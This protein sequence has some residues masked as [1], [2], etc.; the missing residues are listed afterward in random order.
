[1][2]HKRFATLERHLP[3]LNCMFERLTKGMLHCTHSSSKFKFGWLTNRKPAFSSCK[4]SAW[5]AP[6]GMWHLSSLNYSL[7]WLTRYARFFL[8]GGWQTNLEWHP[9]GAH[10]R[11]AS[12]FCLWLAHKKN[13]ALHSP[14]SRLN[15]LFSQK[16]CY[17]G[18]TKAPKNQLIR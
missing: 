13:A 14:L 12:K 8:G 10:K 2:A 6:H 17:F 1:M 4:F 7:G 11:Y 3:P 15:F 18:R 9:Q 5:V 16:V